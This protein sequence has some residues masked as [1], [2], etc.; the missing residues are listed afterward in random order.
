MEENL[1]YN[2]NLEESII[3][4]QTLMISTDILIIKR[5]DDRKFL[6]YKLQT[7]RD[8]MIQYE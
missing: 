6:V 2:S 3:D 7:K 4:K 1:I 8:I 5:I